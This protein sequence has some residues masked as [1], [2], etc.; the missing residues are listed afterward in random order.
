MTTAPDS[1]AVLARRRAAL[2][3]RNV[4][5]E[6]RWRRFQTATRERYGRLAS[7]PPGP[8]LHL[9]ARGKP[10]GR[11]LLLAISGLWLK[12]AA[13][14]LGADGRSASRLWAYAK[15][16]PDPQ[17]QPSALFDQAWYLAQHPTL[18]ASAWP[19]LA[20][21]LIEG[22]RLGYAPHPL[23]DQA[24]ADQSAGRLLR[25]RT[26]LHRHLA[27]GAAAGANPHALFDTRYYVGRCEA[28]A[29]S[30][31]NP[32]VHYL[33]SGWQGGLNPHPLFDNDWYL[34]THPQARAAGVAPLLHYVTAGAA[35]GLDPHPLFDTARYL[36]QGAQTENPLGEFLN[37][38]GRD[39][40]VPAPHFHPAYY[41]HRA[42]H[43]QAARDNPL[44]HYLTIGAFE[45]L[46]PAPEFDEAA[47]LG[48]HPDVPDDMAA[49]DHWARQGA[50][51]ADI[52]ALEPPRG[53][54][55]QALYS[56]YRLAAWPD[57]PAM[58]IAAHAELRSLIRETAPGLDAG[59]SDA[60]PLVLAFRSP[61]AP[62]WL[63]VFRKS[64][65]APEAGLADP[66]TPEALARDERLA[67]R[68]GVTLVHEAA[69][70]ADARVLAAATQ[71]HALA[72]S[73]PAPAPQTIA[74]LLASPLMLRIA[75][76]PLV[77][78]DDAPAPWRAAGAWVV[79]RGSPDDGFDGRLAAI[80]LASLAGPVAGY[81]HLAAAAGL[82]PGAFQAWLE[83]ALAR[84]ALDHP[85][86]ERLIFIDSWNGWDR[87]TAI[88][89]D[90]QFGHSWLEAVSNAQDA[91]LLT[92]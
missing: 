74:E 65:R 15:A 32:L 85:P 51:Q 52:K 76:R 35:E 14:G 57:P 53:A 61:R 44:L 1:E 75:G 62:D 63:K 68:R 41:L 78:T 13:G 55:A 66:A 70:E 42:D 80:S 47:Y 84:A 10:P 82:R 28:V 31:E 38:R 40:R 92:P 17:V 86:G 7:G 25:G 56:H 59:Q 79:A 18:A 29:R 22:A 45:G 12:E 91:D 50:D 90:L 87:Q 5:A 64:R 49:L 33:R 30:G 81:P 34:D 88:A 11:A 8:L 43:A 83:A 71:R 54:S 4:L 58:E 89:P 46:W 26:A 36:G 48:A 2:A 67:A 23:I 60:P 73:G 77:V 27:E 37:S 72:W 6:D 3:A 16:G 24:V 69:D 21:Y 9:L 20:H 19:P 39:S